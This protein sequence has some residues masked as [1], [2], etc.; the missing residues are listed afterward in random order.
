MQR[1]ALCTDPASAIAAP[2]P[3]ACIA[4]ELQYLLL[5]W[6]GFCERGLA[7]TAA[8]SAAASPGSVAAGAQDTAKADELRQSGNKLYGS[9]DYEGA[10]ALYAKALEAVPEA[11]VQQRAVVH[12]NAAA[13]HLKLAQWAEA[14]K[15]ASAALEA[16]PG[17]E[18][19]LLRRAAAYEELAD[20]ERALADYETVL[21]EHPDNQLAGDAVVR[22][23]P[24][25]TAQREKLKEEMFGKLKELGNTVLG[26]FG[27]SLDNF[28][29]DKDP[30]T[31]SYSISFQQ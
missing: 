2:Q 12:A 1:S 11:A 16:A 10:L 26:K 14:A 15:A 24:V 17:H 31:G 22:L 25:V 5:R 18:K 4:A 13:A 7:A 23:T 30:A 20:L 6:R 27:M 9:G 19:A 3:A 29:A 28:K 8:A 21:K